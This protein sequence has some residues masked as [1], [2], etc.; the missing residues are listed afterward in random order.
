MVSSKSPSKLQC[1]DFYKNWKINFKVFSDM[2]PLT[3][4]RSALPLS[5]F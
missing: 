5:G 4:T 2:K 3:S 1:N